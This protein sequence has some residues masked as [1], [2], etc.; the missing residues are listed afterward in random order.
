METLC[1]Y[2]F[3]SSDPKDGS[4]RVALKCIA[5]ILLL[6]SKTRQIFVQEGHAIKVAEKLNDSQEYEL[7]CSRILFLLTYD[8]A[9]NFDDLF[10]NFFLADK[11]HNNI[12]HEAE[13]MDPSSGINSS[14]PLGWGPLTETLKLT[15][16]LTSLY[17]HR[18]SAFNSTLSPI[19]AILRTMQTQTPILQPPLTQLINILLNLNLLGKESESAHQH[20]K[21]PSFFPTSG[22]N[23][24]VSRLVAILDS[25]LR[26]TSEETLETAAIPLITLLRRA[27]DLAPSS[28]KTHMQS[29]LLPS[30]EERTQPLGRSD[31]LAS[32]L[33]RLSTSAVAPNLREGISSLL[34]ELSDKEATSFVRNVGYGF[35]AG[36]LMTHNLP[37]PDNTLKSD[38]KRGDL[39]GRLTNIDGKEVNPVTG[40]RRDMEPEDLG[41]E[42][43]EEEKE[44]EAERLFVLFER[45]KATGVVNV[46]NPVQ[47]AV[48]EGRV[49]ELE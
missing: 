19:L 38:D 41:P 20:G 39:G 23:I 13:Q 21:N 32:C 11:I 8:T 27:Y 46:V 37:I 7:L 15:F 2:A 18:I 33:L 25:A 10:D 24:H 29:A 26:T 31:T 44:I 3:K 36:F 43:T 30:N 12:R 22:P 45:L 5:N 6:E 34:F 28:V 35:A 17:P 14:S 48:Q 1:Y 49:E 16:N 40:Q 9:Y 42:M 4:S 47:Q